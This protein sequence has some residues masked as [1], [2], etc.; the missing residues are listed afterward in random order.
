MYEKYRSASILPVYYD[1]TQNDWFLLLALSSSISNASWGDLGGALKK[2]ESWINAAVREFIEESLGC[3]NDF[4]E[5]KLLKILEK[6]EYL[7]CIKYESEIQERMYFLVPMPM[8]VGCSEH[9][10]EVRKLILHTPEQKGIA[11]P[12]KIK[13]H[14]AIDRNDRSIKSCYLEKQQIKW[15]SIDTLIA[16]LNG[17]FIKKSFRD[18]LRQ[19]IRYFLTEMDP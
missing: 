10:D 3:V 12:D 6:G 14:P 4:T 15:F 7:K 8:E 17:P 5:S 1:K 11:I 16:M 19:T 13:T 18:I 9:F 2:D